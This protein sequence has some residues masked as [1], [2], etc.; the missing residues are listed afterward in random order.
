MGIYTERKLSYNHN[1]NEMQEV[2]TTMHRGNDDNDD[3]D[4]QGRQQ[5]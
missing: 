1:S 2:T 5:Q 4:V 3:D